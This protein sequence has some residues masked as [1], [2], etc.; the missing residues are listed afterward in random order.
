MKTSV[1]QRSGGLKIEKN[2][3]LFLSNDHRIQYDYT[4]K[5]ELQNPEGKKSV[6]GITSAW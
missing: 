6:L 4:Y 1:R 3:S 2:V 5:S